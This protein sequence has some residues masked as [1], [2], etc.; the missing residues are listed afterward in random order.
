MITYFEKFIDIFYN[1]K[2]NYNSTSSVIEANAMIYFEFNE[3]PDIQK[4][5]VDN[6]LTICKKNNV[7][8]FYVYDTLTS[9]INKSSSN[10]QHY[11]WCIKMLYDIYKKTGDDIYK[12]YYNKIISFLKKTHVKNNF[13][14]NWIKNKDD[15]L[16]SI[17]YYAAIDSIYEI[18]IDFFEF[19]YKSIKYHIKNNRIYSCFN[20][21]N[22]TNFNKDNEFDTHQIMEL[23]EGLLNIYEIS[24]EKKYY[25]ICIN[26]IN[27]IIDSLICDN[28]IFSKLQFLYFVKKY[29]IDIKEEYLKI[30]LNYA[31]FIININII[32]GN[33][34]V[35]FKNIEQN[36]I[37]SLVYLN[38]LISNK[39]ITYKLFGNIVLKG[40]L[41]NGTCP[42]TREKIKGDNCM[43]IGN[44]E[45]LNS[46]SNSNS[47]YKDYEI[48]FDTL[49]PEINTNYESSK[50]FIKLG[51][52][53]NYKL[54]LNEIGVFIK[55]NLFNR[56]NIV[57]YGS[58]VN[59]YNIYKS[60]NIKNTE[61]NNKK[62]N[63]NSNMKL[64]K[65]NDYLPNKNDLII[66]TNEEFKDHIEIYS[67]NQHKYIS[68]INFIPNHILF[69]L[70]DKYEFSNFLL[71]FN[72]KPIPFYNNLKN[73]QENKKYVLKTKESVCKDRLRGKVLYK[74]DLKNMNIDFNKYF[75]QDFI[76][77]GVLNKSVCGYFDYMSNKLNILLTVEKII[78]YGTDINFPCGA[79]IKTTDEDSL[80]ERTINI[81]QNLQ[82]RGPFEL[83]FIFDKKSN[84]NY[85]CELNPR[86]W[87]QNAIFNNETNNMI[88][89][90]YIG[91]KTIFN[92]KCLNKRLWI[93]NSYFSDKN[94][95]NNINKI[96]TKYKD[97]H[98]IIYSHI[99]PLQ[100]SKT[101]DN[102]HNEHTEYYNSCPRLAYYLKAIFDIFNIDKKLSIMEYATGSGRS[103]INLRKSGYTNCFGSDFSEKAIQNLK[104]YNYF[105]HLDFFNSKEK[106]DITFHDGLMIYFSCFETLID[107]QLKN[108]NKYSII[109]LHNFLNKNLIKI[110]SEKKNNDILYD[111]MWHDF[112]K[113]IKYIKDKYNYKVTIF[114]YGYLKDKNINLDNYLKNNYINNRVDKTF[115][116]KEF[117][118][119]NDIYPIKDCE[120][121]ILVIEK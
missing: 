101:W 109:V 48:Y 32:Y 33:S 52:I 59:G 5:I 49:L 90:R 8:C 106:Y 19:I 23:F 51:L 118:R 87:M 100:E 96:I 84:I 119:L 95:N 65:S 120:R 22:K 67:K 16:S 10:A 38:R 60:I 17:K 71:Q 105:K 78:G 111:I 103:V 14:I 92:T 44:S 35:Y 72:E 116:R 40:K 66:W 1:I 70:D 98:S 61:F 58:G 117:I 13:L 91:D 74:K 82:F 81:L 18:D 11:I 69:P 26:E 29:K 54:I 12:N 15:N 86:F 30:L 7:C 113:C 6:F 43:F 97:S 77:Y 25:D 50:R 37:F 46:N 24:G 68:H 53:K 88:V 104:E 121:I 4:R 3:Y 57:I 73:I 41:C 39:Y 89:Q 63:G 94:I 9:E 83:E 55:N 99:S 102:I 2:Q 36:N 28:S 114:K 79:V 47:K 42:I 27:T 56:K 75:I 93:L 20:I 107:I 108:T 45:I 31:R 34:P 115:F 80:H 112:Y 62:I 85:I 64:I 110:F 21:D 76:E